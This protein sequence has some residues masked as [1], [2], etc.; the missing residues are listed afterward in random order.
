M[1]TCTGGPGVEDRLERLEHGEHKLGL[2]AFQQPA[3]RL[4]QP[5]RHEG[6]Y[7][8]ARGADACVA[9]R[10]GS[11]FEDVV[12]LGGEHLDQPRHHT[13]GAHGIDLV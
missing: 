10:V 5:G 11:L 7:R 12:L 2:G 13:R 6:G 9:Q 3:Q 8:G 1:H 4:D